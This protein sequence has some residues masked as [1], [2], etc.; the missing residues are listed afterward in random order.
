MERWTN[1]I[2]AEISLIELEED[3]YPALARLRRLEPVCYLPALGGWLVTRHD[4]AAQ[5]MRDS[6][7]F[8]V[9]DPRFS[10]ARVVGPSMLSRDGAAHERFRAPFVGPLR[11]GAL[12]NWPELT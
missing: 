3:P 4:L 11:P 10:T 9:D 8:T 5:V 6:E 7:T 2:G 12:P 1:S